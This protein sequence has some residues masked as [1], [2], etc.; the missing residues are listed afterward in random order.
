[1]NGAP[2]STGAVARDRPKWDDKSDIGMRP[3]LRSMCMS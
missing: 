1:M 2:G 3:S